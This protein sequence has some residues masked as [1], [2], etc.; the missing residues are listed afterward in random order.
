MSGKL[1]LVLCGA[2]LCL[3]ASCVESDR[4]LSDVLKSE[5]DTRLYGLWSRTGES[6]DTEYLH[7][8]AELTDPLERNRPQAEPGLMRYATITHSQ[9]THGLGKPSDGRFYRS[10]INGDDYANWVVPADDARRK[11]VT[12]CFLKYQV[13]DQQLVLWDQDAEATAKAIEG[14]KLKG[15][16]KRKPGGD[17]FEELRITDSSEN[18]AKFLAGGGDKT[19]FPDKASSKYVY[20]RVR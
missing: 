20:K 12:Y 1:R 15:V 8:G 13:D 14:G 2:V 17:S 18:V 7:V 5:Q 3:L 16:V 9:H 4:P 19:C 11:P 6:G 10:K